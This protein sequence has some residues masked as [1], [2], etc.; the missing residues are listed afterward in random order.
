MKTYEISCEICQDLIPL[1]K[2]DI[3]SDD[4]KNAVYNHI[5]NCKVCQSYM[6]QETQSETI[7]DNKLIRSIKMIILCW[8]AIVCLISMFIACGLPKTPHS[9][10]IMVV[11]LPA[12]SAFACIFLNKKWIV[13]PVCVFISRLIVQAVVRWRD[14][15]PGNFFSVSL[16]DLVSNFALVA[17]C[18]IGASIYYLIKFASHE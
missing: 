17:L 4:T 9:I 15:I 13:I 18:F 2:D 11:A 6:G 8:T 12:L 3:A 16:N 5:Q 1:V 10:A 14:F 7:S